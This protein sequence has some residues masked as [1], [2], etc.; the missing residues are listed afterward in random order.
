MAAAKRKNCWLLSH[1]L[2]VGALA[3]SLLVCRNVLNKQLKISFLDVGQGDAILIQTPEH[4]NILIDAGPDSNV[5]NNLGKE[6]NFFNKTIDLF[7]LTHPDKDHMGGAIDVMQK[8]SIKYAVLTGLA[9]D[10]E[11]YKA[12]LFEIKNRS[13]VVLL[14]TSEQDIRIGQ[15][16]YLDIIYPLKGLNFVGQHIK[17]KNNTSI[18]ARLRKRDNKSWKNLIMLTGD[19]EIIAERAILLSGQDAKADIL[20]LG[21]H[22][23]KTAT[24]REFLNAVVPRA[25]VVSAGKDN[26]FGHPHPETMEKVKGLENRNTMEEGDIT[27]IFQ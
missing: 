8:Y 12:F 20:K 23:S 17:D 5:T 2:L 7:V 19:A 27:F 4:K 3:L 10:N 22:G 15:N 13:I 6:L 21:H 11:L 26:S 16:E 9:P 18:A 25:V 24:S 1:G 14:A